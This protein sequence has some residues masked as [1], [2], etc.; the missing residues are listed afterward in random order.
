MKTVLTTSP[1]EAAAYIRSGGIAA[2]ATETVYGLGAD[3]FNEAAIRKIFAAKQRP[4]DN[5][6]I[7]HISSRNQIVSLALEVTDAAEKLMGAFFPG[8]LTVVLQKRPEVP[9]VATA[10]L[11]TIGIRMTALVLAR[12]FLTHCKTPVAAPS[13]NLSGRPS[14]TTWQAVI[15]PPN[16]PPPN[17][18]ESPPPRPACSSTRKISALETAMVDPSTSN[19]SLIKLRM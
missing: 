2:F 1:E 5:P 19:G 16:E 6:L 12:E 18:S 10:G 3:V 13:A 15:D 14:P 4:A 11:D 17:M 9:D 8:P 7:A